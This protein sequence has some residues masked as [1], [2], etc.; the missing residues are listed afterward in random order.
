LIPDKKLALPS[1]PSS[2]PTHEDRVAWEDLADNQLID[3]CID[4]DEQAWT[5]LINRYSRLIYTIPLRFGFPKIVA[6]EVFQ[7]TCLTLL[8]SLDSLQE[9]DR[10]RS[11]LVTVCRRVC[12]QHRRQKKEWQSLDGVTIDGRFPPLDSE[13]IQLEQQHLVHEALAKLPPRCQQLLQALF[14]ETPPASYEEIAHQLN[15]STGSIGPTR[16][17]CLEKLQQELAKSDHH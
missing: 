1:T 15:I 5:T 12:I 13:L 3:A 2:L 7:E 17:R 14:F 6:D 10:V 4:G 9:K 8:E 11:W 16:I